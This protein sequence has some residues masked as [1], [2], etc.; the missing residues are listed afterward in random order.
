MLKLMNDE[1]FQRYPVFEELIFEDHGYWV[2]TGI[3]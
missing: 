3:Q 1:F 2:Q